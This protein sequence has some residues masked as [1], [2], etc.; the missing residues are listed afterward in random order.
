MIPFVKAHLLAEAWVR[1]V[2]DGKAEL[3]AK[4]TLAKPYGWIFFYQ[5][6]A[7]VRDRSNHA[8]SLVGNAPILVDRINGEIRVLGT[9]Q[10]FQQRLADYEQSLP[11]ACL[12][13]RPEDPSW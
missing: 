8:A 9:G 2:T 13:M 3:L 6:S 7:Y 12:Q 1:A 11:P 10:L 5:S 4:S